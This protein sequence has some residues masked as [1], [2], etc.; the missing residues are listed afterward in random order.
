MSEQNTQVAPEQ[1]S[2]APAENAPAK[3]LAEQGFVAETQTVAV[4]EVEY[5]VTF[6]T[7]GGNLKVWQDHFTALGLNADEVIASYVD[8]VQTQR[9]TQGGKTK[10]R[11]AK[12]EAKR[13]EAVAEHQSKAPLFILGKPAEKAGKGP[14]GLTQKKLTEVGAALVSKAAERGGNITPEDL[15]DI[16]KS[17]GID[18]VKLGLAP[19][20]PAAEQEAT[21]ENTAPVA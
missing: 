16:A 1:G 2:T 17:L 21:E 5:P 13:A 15:A 4:G 14:G 11:N 20:A 10:V 18:V 7:S 9:A 8:E 3:S 19:A 12:D 6:Y